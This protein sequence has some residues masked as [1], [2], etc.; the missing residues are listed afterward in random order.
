MVSIALLGEADVLTGQLLGPRSPPDSL[1]SFVGVHVPKEQ[2][3]VKGICAYVPQVSGKLSFCT[4]CYYN[5]IPFLQAAW[6]RN[7]SIR[8]Q[9]YDQA[10]H[11]FSDY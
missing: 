4:S 10:R 7:A 1:A 2:W 5:P 6:L 11:A 3:I 9:F 8:G